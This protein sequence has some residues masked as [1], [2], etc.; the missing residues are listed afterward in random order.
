MESVYQ[1]QV[2]LLALIGGLSIGLAGLAFQPHVVE[3]SPTAIAVGLVLLAA[4]LFFFASNLA[5]SLFGMLV[6]G[7]RIGHIEE[8]LN[9]IVGQT[10]LTWESSIAPTIYPRFKL[11]RFILIPATLVAA[12]AAVFATSALLLLVLAWSTLIGSYTWTYGA[13]LFGAAIF[14]ALQWGGIVF[15][16]RATIRDIV[17]GE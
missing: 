15:S 8:Q 13:F 14:Q 11:S 1:S 16:G 7:S 12:W 2:R 10:V 17:R 5:D 9:D 6:C 3:F 4:F